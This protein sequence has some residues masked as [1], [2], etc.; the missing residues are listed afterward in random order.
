MP[1][2]NTAV[3]PIAGR[4]SSSLT[5]SPRKRGDS[6]KMRRARAMASGW[7]RSPGP[8]TRSASG[9]TMRGAGPSRAPPPGTAALGRGQAEHAL[10][11]EAAQL[12]EG[13][14]V[15]RLGSLDAHVLDGEPG[16]AKGDV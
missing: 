9:S 8:M 13:G 1:F 11:L 16:R 15:Q 4:Y 12:H 3:T 5:P 10:A 7:T 6:S 14:G 2:S